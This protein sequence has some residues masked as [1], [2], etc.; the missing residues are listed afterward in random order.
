MKLLIIHSLCSGR[1]R[2][3]IPTANYNNLNKNAQPSKNEAKT[4]EF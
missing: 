2:A 1:K 4:R 3:E